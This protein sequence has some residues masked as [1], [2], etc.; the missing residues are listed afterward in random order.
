ME[1]DTL[2][3]IRKIQPLLFRNEMVEEG[4]LD[5]FRRN[6]LE[7]SKGVLATLRMNPIY[8]VCK[9]TTRHKI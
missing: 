4:H 1:R 9:Q 5:H 8:P 6:N 7:S 2:G 3:K